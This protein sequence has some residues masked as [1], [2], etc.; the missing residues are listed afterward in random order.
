LKSNNSGVKRIDY[1]QARAAA[2]THERDLITPYVEA[3]DRVI[4][5]A[6][7]Q[8]AKISAAVDPLGGTAL[9]YWERIAEYWKLDLTIVNRRLDPR[10]DFMTVDHDG[11]IR[12][13]CSSPYAMASLVALKDK[14]ALAFGNDADADRHGIVAPSVGLLNPNHYLAVAIEFLAKHRPQWTSDQAIG[15]TLVSSAIIDRV[16]SSVGRK[17]YEVPVGFKWFSSGLFDGSLCFGGEESAGASFLCHDGSAWS[18]DKDGILLC[19]LAME[20]IAKTG[21]DPGVRYARLEQRFGSPT[22]RRVD[23]PASAQQKARFKSLPPGSL[24]SRELAGETIEA[25][26][27]H[28]PG[29]GA[30]LGGIKV[31]TANAWFAARPSGTEDVYKIYGESFLG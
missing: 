6:A 20:M 31:V 19:L 28:A 14:Y 11:K 18:T 9:P 12:M 29:N 27:T 30:A 10:F 1:A 5:M 16:V 25:V 2:T 26:L 4:D 15:K 21:E 13:D 23:A 24:S 7:I 22:Y 3:L 8:N 17:L